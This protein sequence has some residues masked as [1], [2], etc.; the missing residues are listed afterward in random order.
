MY[1]ICVSAEISIAYTTY[2]IHYTHI[3]VC[4]II[5]CQCKC[6]ADD[7]VLIVRPRDF[8]R[9]PPINI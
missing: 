9:V 3:A 7:D 1:N 6:D 5:V 4:Y 8:M 2:I